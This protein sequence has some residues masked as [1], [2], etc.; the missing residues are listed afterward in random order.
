MHPFDVSIVDRFKILQKNKKAQIGSLTLTTFAV[1]EFRR[2]GNQQAVSCSKTLHKYANTSLKRK[3]NHYALI[4]SEL[5][6]IRCKGCKKPLLFC[7]S[8]SLLSFCQAFCSRPLRFRY[9]DS[10][11]EK[12]SLTEFSG[13]FTFL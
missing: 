10:A 11:A 1:T 5:V 12:F 2:D 13:N 9:A 3:I 4:S 6:C 8:E 7:C